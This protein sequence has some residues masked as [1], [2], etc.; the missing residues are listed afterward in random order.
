MRIDVTFRHMAPSRALRDY[1]SDKVSRITRLLHRPISAHVTL[2]LDGFRNVVECSVHG[3]GTTLTARETSTTDMYA[4]IDIVSDKL[5]SQ[6]RKH[7]GRSTEHR[8]SPTA[9]RAAQFETVDD[10]G[11]E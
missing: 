8:S 3:R 6:A 5:T 10:T 11:D 4:A 1:T 2:T 9:E 7:K